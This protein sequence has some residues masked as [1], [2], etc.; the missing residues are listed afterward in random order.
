MKK[1][2]IL[3]TTFVLLLSFTTFFSQDNVSAKPSTS[4]TSSV[5]TDKQK[6]ESIKW[7]DKQIAKLQ[8]QIDNLEMKKQRLSI[9][10]KE[11]QAV[12]IQQNNL[13][14]KTIYYLSKQIEILG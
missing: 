2:T 6:M 8:H 7:L 5:N 3:F 1:L 13:I 14:N 9:S 10:S 12:I 11:Y 4:S